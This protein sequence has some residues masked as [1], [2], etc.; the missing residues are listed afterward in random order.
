MGFSGLGYNGHVFWDTE[1]WMYPPLLLILQPEIARSLL[2]Y[3][4]E[5]MEMAKPGKTPFRTVI[6]ALCFPGSPAADGSGGHAG[7]G[8]HRAFSAPHHRLRG[9][10]LLATIIW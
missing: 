6:P 3:R 9:L 2:D 8:A 7:V 1:L 4:F 10:G 5:R